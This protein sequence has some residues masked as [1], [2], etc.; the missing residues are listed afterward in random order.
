MQSRRM[1][2]VEAV[3]N[4]AIGFGVSWTANLVILPAYG[5]HVSSGQAFSIGLWFT[6]I[7]LARSYAVRRLFCR[8]PAD[9][10]VGNND[11]NSRL[12]ASEMINRP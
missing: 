9:R 11:S 10:P 6:A 3:A 1:S 12:P 2:V 4:V 7:S 8:L 5:Y